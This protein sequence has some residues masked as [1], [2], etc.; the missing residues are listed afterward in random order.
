[1]V[2]V[3]QY[4]SGRSKKESTLLGQSSKILKTIK[5]KRILTEMHDKMRIERCDGFQTVYIRQ[6][7]GE[8]SVETRERS[9]ICGSSGFV[10]PSGTLRRVWCEEARH[11]DCAS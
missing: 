10:A 4:F 11:G 5:K 3:L 7:K 1:M 9:T 8:T 2:Q 6:I